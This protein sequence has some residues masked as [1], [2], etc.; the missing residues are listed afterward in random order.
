MVAPK[1]GNPLGRGKSTEV[2]SCNAVGLVNREDGE[3]CG[4]PVQFC[5]SRGL[6]F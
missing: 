5:L 2:Q 4:E 1:E 3:L 6:D